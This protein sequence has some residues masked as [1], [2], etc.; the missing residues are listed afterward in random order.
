MALDPEK[1]ETMRE[2]RNMRKVKE[3]PGSQLKMKIRI[4][5]DKGRGE[6]FYKIILV[7][8]C[9]CVCVCVCV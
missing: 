8:L 3:N 6:L 2:T 4:L 7:L 1:A 9:V 5:S